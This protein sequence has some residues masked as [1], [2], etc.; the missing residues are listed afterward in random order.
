MRT[1]THT[2]SSLSGI[3]RSFQAVHKNKIAFFHLINLYFPVRVFV[4]SSWHATSILLLLNSSEI[5]NEKRKS[6]CSSITDT[7]VLAPLLCV[8]AYVYFHSI[9]LGS[10]NVSTVLFFVLSFQFLQ[11][12]SVMCGAGNITRRSLILVKILL[13]S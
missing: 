5:C 3:H 9:W 13:E 4:S 8:R 12:R 10:N 6:R 2:I 7:F 11:L 1:H